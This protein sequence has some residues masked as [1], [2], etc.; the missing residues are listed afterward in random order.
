MR[1]IVTRGGSTKQPLGHPLLGLLLVL[2]VASLAVAAILVTGTTDP[3][4]I[5]EAPTLTGANLARWRP[6][7]GA[8]MTPGWTLDWSPDGRW[9]ALGDNTFVTGVEIVDAATGE[10]GYTMNNPG[11]VYSVRWSPDGR[12]LAV[13]AEE[14]SLGAGPGSV[15][16]YSREGN[17]E[18]SWPAINLPTTLNGVMGVDW[19]PDGTRVVGAQGGRFLV[20]DLAS[21]TAVLQNGNASVN[22][23]SADWSPDGRLLLFG[24]TGGATVFD[25]STG[26][27]RARI[28]DGIPDTRAAAWSH[29]G[30]LI[31]T[32][33]L[34]GCAAV[35]RADGA[36]VWSKCD[37]PEFGDLWATPPSWSPD[38][39]LLAVANAQGILIM[40]AASGSLLR[41]LEFPVQSY[42][43]ARGTWTRGDSPYLD[44]AAAFSPWGNVLA[45]VASTTH[46][47]LRLWGITQ[48]PVTPL[49]GVLGA[50]VAVG[51]PLSLGREFAAT[52][53]RPDLLR[54]NLRT[55]TRARRVGGVLFIF[56]FVFAVIQATAGELMSRVSEARAIPP[57]DWYLQSIVLSAALGAVGALLGLLAFRRALWP[58]AQSPTQPT[59]TR[60]VAVLGWCLVPVVW[61]VAVAIAS[62]AGLR[63]VGVGSSTAIELSVLVAL[64]TGTGLV[65]ASRLASTLAG[66]T[67]LRSVGA[68]L[69]GTVLYIGTIVAVFLASV[70]LLN[71]LQIPPTPEIARYGITVTFSFGLTPFLLAAA[72]SI[73]LAVEGA[74]VVYPPKALLFLYTRLRRT[75]VLDLESRRQ[76]LDYVRG[77]PGVHFREL[78]RSLPFG[79]G[80]L[81]YHLYVLEREGYL[82]PQRD[83][84]YRRFFA[85]WRV[86]TSAP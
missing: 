84:M 72:G 39:T 75:Q 62:I 57:L 86:D 35:F 51:L 7:Y 20:W 15:S 13:G 41:T 45:S 43:P 23:N 29:S 50:T 4:G 85:I 46:P 52:V 1:C 48:G 3:Y 28:T 5:Q 30:Q 9:I 40:D 8:V 60:T 22:G 21:G 59:V 55:T 64:I 27:L 76:I 53:N 18:R 80:S 81:H 58:R 49:V 33:A 34:D 82:I 79:S 67:F 14:P 83:G 10:V 31:G 63:L 6:I 37:H 47:S 74:L 71:L 11:W 68:L 36:Q 61:T 56:A 2:I 12:H 24:Y 66:R 78:L 70:E 19:S 44:F 54:E 26:A 42:G 32:A 77:H 69:A 16:V 25:A 65:L 73:V 17:L 38:D